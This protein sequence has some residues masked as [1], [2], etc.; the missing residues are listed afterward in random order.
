MVAGDTTP[1][2]ERT[3]RTCVSEAFSFPSRRVGC[4][5][6][7]LPNR[8]G[9][10]Y[11]LD[12]VQCAETHVCPPMWRSSASLL[13][14]SSVDTDF[15]SVLVLVLVLLHLVSCLF[16]LLRPH[17]RFPLLLSCINLWSQLLPCLRRHILLCVV[18]ENQAFRK[19]GTK[20]DNRK[21]WP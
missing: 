19:D 10:G 11:G 7:S 9:G 6:F 17:P 12:L 2:V 8:S 4:V 13:G 20:K 21:E 3:W 18:I 5:V 14:E 16:L 1:P 15:V